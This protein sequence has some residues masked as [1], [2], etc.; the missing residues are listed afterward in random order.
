MDR[1]DLETF[2]RLFVNHRPV[3][4]IGRPHIEDGFKT[5]F[6]DEK[7]L[8]NI[9]R[10]IFLQEIGSEGEPLMNQELGGLLEKLVG[11]PSIKEALGDSIDPEIF[12]KEILSFEEVEEDDDDE[13]DEAYNP[14]YYEGSPNGTYNP[15][16][17]PEEP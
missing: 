6:K 7:D 8:A 17:I 11:K 5:L 1:F 4:G 16:I 3:F 14:A 10:E 13:I 9:A 15:A 2:I 12:A